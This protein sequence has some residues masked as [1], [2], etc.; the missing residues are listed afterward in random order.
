MVSRKSE[1]AGVAASIVTCWVTAAYPSAT[2]RTLAG[3]AGT[4]LSR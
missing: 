2:T 1:T 4:L 3:P